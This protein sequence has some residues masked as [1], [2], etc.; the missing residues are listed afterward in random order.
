MNE[1]QLSPEGEPVRILGNTSTEG[2]GEETLRI[3]YKKESLDTLCN[4][5]TTPEKTIVRRRSFRARVN[6]RTDRRC[7]CASVDFGRDRRS[8]MQLAPH[9]HAQTVEFPQPQFINKGVDDRVKVQRT[10]PTVHVERDV[11]ESV[12][13]QKW[14]ISAVQQK[15]DNR[16]KMPQEQFQRVHE[17]IEIPQLQL[18]QEE[19]RTKIAHMTVEKTFEERDT[20]NQ[21]VV[22][23]VNGTAW[24]WSIQQEIWER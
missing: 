9:E 15:I 11:S 14:R 1:E 6:R 23:I 7:A 13:R 2:I 18:S 5:L 17:K 21:A 20:L 8:V 12:Q 19:M 10:G 3:R 22:R 24:A 16:E 4:M